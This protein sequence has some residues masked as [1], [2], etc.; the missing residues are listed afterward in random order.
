M[1]ENSNYQKSKKKKNCSYFCCKNS[2]TIFL[3]LEINRNHHKNYYNFDAKIQFFFTP[4]I[5]HLAWLRTFAFDPID[6]SPPSTFPLEKIPRIELSFS[7]I[8]NRWQ[9]QRRR[10]SG[11]FCGQKGAIY[12]RT[13]QT[14][15]SLKGLYFRF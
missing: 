6:D 3:N 15:M 7:T 5:F 9:R 4:S 11:G 12:L 2:D 13:L 8:Q 10:W 1:S 14:I